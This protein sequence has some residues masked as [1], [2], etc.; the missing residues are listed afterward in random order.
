MI[1]IDVENI[2]NR[3]IIKPLLNEGV[4]TQRHRDEINKICDKYDRTSI[5]N[6]MINIYHFIK[7][8][9][10]GVIPWVKRLEIIRKV[11]KNDIASEYAL[12]IRYGKSNLKEK[13]LELSLKF[14]HTLE[15]YIQKHGK[16]IG[17][18]KYNEY[19]KKSKTPW[20]L[21]SCVEKY[22]DVEG[23]RKWEERL[24]KKI[25]TQ[26]ERKKSKPY[27]N[28]RTLKEYQDRYGVKDGYFKWQKRNE[29]QSYR[30]SKKYYED[31]YGI[32]RGSNKWE[33][34]KKSMDKTSLKS[35]INRYG[36]DNGF[37]KYEDYLNKIN[38]SGIF[39]SKSSQRLF[40]LIYDELSDERK[41]LCRFAKLNGEEY[42]I[43]NKYGLN[44]IL[45][46]FKCGNKIIEFD[47]DYWHLNETQKKIDKLRDKFL[48][49]KGYKI[50]RVRDSEFEINKKKVINKC[51]KFI[52]ND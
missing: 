34:Y 1:K 4:I 13:K 38:D 32:K 43:V 37:V 19:L 52:K 25:K 45:V 33:E 31:T 26:N 16:K 21:K 46:D 14:S 17:E 48:I 2:V 44:N 22:G 39:Y 6:R 27:R 29:K 5:K 28:G 10:D 49:S 50:L 15:K 20:G 35:F 47:G 9:V 23:K 42:F 12:E 24:N 40:W 18:E 7:Y 8:D 3:K 36:E 51:I 11:L 41:K 30:F